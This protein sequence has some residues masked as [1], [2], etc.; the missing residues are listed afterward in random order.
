MAIGPS[1]TV[2]VI[3]PRD[4]GESRK[5]DEE[6]KR[7]AWRKNPRGGDTDCSRLPPRVRG[8]S[9]HDASDLWPLVPRSAPRAPRRHPSRSRVGR[10]LLGSLAAYPYDEEGRGE[11]GSC[12]WI[13]RLPLSD[14]RFS[15]GS[16]P[17]SGCFFLS[18]FHAHVASY[19]ILP[20]VY[21]FFPRYFIYPF[22]L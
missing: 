2:G 15:H 14:D 7:I 9:S 19:K 17:P 20:L 8:L 11:G 4:L 12:M 22:C 6:E 10:V 21:P 18:S 1:E 16:R 5:W 13:L 3:T